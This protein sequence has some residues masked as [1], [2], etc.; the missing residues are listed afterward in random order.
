MTLWIVFL[1][2]GNTSFI[3]RTMNRNSN[4]VL[5]MWAV[6]WRLHKATLFWEGLCEK[7]IKAFS[8][9]LKFKDFKL[10]LET[11][12]RSVFKIMS[13]YLVFTYSISLAKWTKEQHTGNKNSPVRTCLSAAGDKRIKWIKPIAE[14]Q[15]HTFF[16]FVVSRF[17]VDT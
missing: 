13:K 6:I 10:L 16:L 11:G 7:C 9:M 17:Y 4:G 3:G 5:E 2:V 15:Y 14:R 8:L 12:I 1:R